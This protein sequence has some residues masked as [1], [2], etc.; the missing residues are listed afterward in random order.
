[1]EDRLAQLEIERILQRKVG[2]FRA[3][4]NERE[5]E[6]FEQRMLSDT[7]L[8][9]QEIGDRHGVSKER[10]RQI[11]NKLI[12]RL[13]AFIRE[14]IPDFNPEDLFRE[15]EKKNRKQAAMDAK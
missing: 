4:L 13:R 10:I 2:E 6:I 8:T 12:Q 3:R 1:V 14:E 7:P 9:L 15:E 11:E 5:Q